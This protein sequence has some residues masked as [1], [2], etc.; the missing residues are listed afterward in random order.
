M[1]FFSFEK[2]P[3]KEEEKSRIIN[4][5]YQSGN[6]QQEHLCPTVINIFNI[7]L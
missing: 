3:E 1:N 5:S 6:I 7:A 4:K 2:K